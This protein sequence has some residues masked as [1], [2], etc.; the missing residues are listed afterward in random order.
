[1][2]DN[3]SAAEVPFVAQ[4]QR[5]V[6]GATD[7]PQTTHE[8]SVRAR[9]AKRKRRLTIAQSQARTHTLVPTGS[10]DRRSA[11]I[12]EAE[13]ERLFDNGVTSLVLD[14]RE[15]DRIDSTG[16]A[17]LAFRSRLCAR[18]G[19][20]LKLMP[21]SRLMQRAFEQ[22]GVTDLLAPPEDRAATGQRP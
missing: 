15:L 7:G 22:A 14:L 13:I 10:L 18:H 1:M 21:G 4:D 20:E 3:H 9:P 2:K 19:Y 6:R 12:L 16:L 11:P 17:V 5:S 8:P